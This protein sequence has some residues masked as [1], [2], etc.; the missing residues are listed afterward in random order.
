MKEITFNKEAFEKVLVGFNKTA[1][2]ITGTI[3]PKGRNVIID[4]PMMPRITNDGNSIANSISFPDKYENLGAWV[5]KNTTAQTNDDAGDG[6]TTTTV[7]LQTIV[8]EA[9]KRPENSVTVKNSLQEAVKGVVEKIEKSSIPVSLEEAKKVALISAEHEDLATMVAEVIQK[10]GTKGAITVEPSRT[11][12]TYYEVVEGY[13]IPSGYASSHFAND[14]AKAVYQNVPVLVTQRKI[15]SVMDIS[16][17]F[18]QM[19]EKSVGNIVIVCEDIDPQILGVLVFNKQI[20]TVNVLVVKAR[21]NELEDIAAVVGA[22]IISEQTGTLF[23]GFNLEKHCGQAQKVTSTEK[24]TIFLADK[25]K[26]HAKKLE[27]LAQLTTNIYEKERLEKRVSQITGGIAIIHVGAVT[28]FDRGY[29][30]DKTRDAVNAV[31]AALEEGV[32]EGGGMALYR[33]ASK[34]KARTIGEEILKKALK[35]PLRKILENAG[36]E[37]AEV[38]MSMPKGKGYDARKDKY[39]DMHKAGIIDPAKVERC[40]VQNAVSNA[41]LFITSHAVIV[42]YVEKK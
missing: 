35:V 28:D 25:G 26:D 3:G 38:L 37:Y 14:G 29:R 19:K 30:V 27:E 15:G 32:V 4:D 1:D 22:E 36:K 2:A 6:R 23:S 10:V 39:V 34:M 18:E 17:I 16:P 9:M 31:K 20:G 41:S 11:Y 13:E 8:K 33:I 42:D 24:K 7:L 21:G 5:V 40:A 12:D